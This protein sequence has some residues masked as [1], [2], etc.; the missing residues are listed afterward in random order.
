VPIHYLYRS[1]SFHELLGYYRSAEIALITPLK[2]GMNLVAKEFC[3]CSIEEN[4]V[5]ILSEFA[6]AAAQLQKGAIL[7][8]P[9]NVEEVSD[10][11]RYAINMDA[12]ER[13]SRM[14]S[15]RRAVRQADIFWW[16]DSFL[17]A[18]IAKNLDDFPVLEDY[19][20]AREHEGF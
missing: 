3:A 6:G 8:N 10:A 1:L 18:G 20:P 15:L 14:R 19:V 12:D 7:V 5:L 17:R 16:V 11:I 4:C 2:D 13:R 9:Y